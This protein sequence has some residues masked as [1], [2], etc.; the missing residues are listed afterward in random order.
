MSNNKKKKFKIIA[1]ISFLLIFAGLVVFLFS[2]ENY[3]VLSEIFRSGATKEEIRSAISKLGFRS[4]LVVG[5]LSMLQVVFTFIPAEPLHV[6]SGVSFGLIKGGLVCLIGIML[7]NTIIYLLT[8][9]FGQRLKDYFTSDSDFD[10]KSASNSNKVALIVILLYI[11][12]AIPYGI[13]C[14]FAAS[15]NMKYF[16]YILIT[17]I[18]SIPSLILDVGLG[19]ITMTTSWAV[20]IA[21][22]IA[23]IVLL[24]LMIKFK[25]PIFKKLNNYVKKSQEKENRKVG[26][27]NPFIFNVCGGAVYLYMNSRVKMKLKNNVGRL[28]KPAIVLCNHGSFFDFVYSGKLLKQEKPHFMV[29]RLFFQNKTLAKI[30]KSTGAF[31]KSM[32]ATDVEN[33]KNCLKVIANK[34]VL[35][36][37]PE[38]RLSTVG[39]FEDI[40][41]ATYKFI[42]KM[43]VPIYT[44]KI[45]GAYLARPKWG[46]GIRKGS[47][48]E[49][50]LNKLMSADECKN[51]GLDEFKSKI[52]NA[53]NYNE[54]SWLESHPEIKYK[55][56]RIAEG[57]ENILSICPECHEKLTIKTHKNQITCEKCNMTATLDNRYQLSGVKFKTIAEWYEWQTN[58]IKEEISSSPTYTLSSKVELR[59]F[60]T[61]GKHL[62][63]HAG[64]GIC[65]LSREGLRYVGTKYNESFE[66]FIPLENIYRLLFGAGEDFELY[67]DDNILY[68]IPEDKRSCVL[69]YIVSGLLKNN[70]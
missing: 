58:L 27:F 53:L 60:G 16:K 12:P 69:W 35:A 3:S 34:E 23:I 4:Y 36:F 9:I 8:K 59:E 66:K 31:P 21:V 63:K 15:M 41:D 56:K 10:F 6:I 52:D 1:L 37:M 39:K 22:F 61:D 65:E 7:G 68:F 13:I 17:G 18:G 11:L 48:V 67:Y 51:L 57:L 5:I 32:F 38:A 20:S 70:S 64:Y 47:L 45:N 33:L 25:K 14:F 28:E 24:L 19:H 30:I 44:V 42:K 54:W 43:N 55:D 26:N 62:T 40:Q 50:E 2:G 29:A 46:N 49:A